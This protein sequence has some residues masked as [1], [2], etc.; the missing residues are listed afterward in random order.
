MSLRQAT[1]LGD[2]VG[3]CMCVREHAA[4]SNENKHKRVSK[5]GRTLEG[6]SS[7]PALKAAV[8]FLGCWQCLKT[9]SLQEVLSKRS[10]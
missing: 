3:L 8:G 6:V 1:C 10:V 7:L 2:C 4:V 9:S 5:R